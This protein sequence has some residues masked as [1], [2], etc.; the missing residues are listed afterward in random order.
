MAEHG[1]TGLGPRQDVPETWGTMRVMDSGSSLDQRDR[2]SLV[3][4]G[5]HCSEMAAIKA[6]D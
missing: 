1:I 2:G 3:V 5:V 6:F 4:A